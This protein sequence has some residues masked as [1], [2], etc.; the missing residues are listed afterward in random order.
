[1]GG[2]CFNGWQHAR[3]LK[4]V[5]ELASTYNTQQRL[6]ET[7]KLADELGINTVNIYTQQLP[8][9][10]RFRE[11]FNHNLKLMVAVAVNKHDL[12]METDHALKAGA[13]LI[14]IQPGV[15]DRLIFY[16]EPEVIS[17]AIDYIRKS[18]LPAG[19]GCYS[20]KTVEAFE[21]F[22]M[23]PD[24][25]VKSIH[26]DNYWS[27]NPKEFREEFDPAFQRFYPEQHRFHDNIFDLFPEKT[28]ETMS[29]LS[30]PW[31][32][33]KTLASG[34]ILPE[35]GF[36]FAF[37]NGADFISAGMF[38]FQ[39]ERNIKTTFNVLKSTSERN[40]NWFA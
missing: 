20:I 1:M 12:F 16:N 9:V 6:E 22:G 18:G 39:I 28:I 8:A 4:Y 27:A 36:R 17:K 11:K 10:Q 29:R 14:Y 13:S 24:F 26:P 15:S 35:E 37:V 33:F 38:D 5:N 32:G 25:Y 21:C 40:R 23:I 31:I 19:I 34:A 30:V 3:D 7:L 2:G